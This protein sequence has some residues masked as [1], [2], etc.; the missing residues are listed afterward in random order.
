MIM[1]NINEKMDDVI[2]ENGRRKIA[3]ECRNKLKQLK[4]LSDKQK[5]SLARAARSDSINK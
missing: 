5:N 3:H 1:S 4:K 2:L